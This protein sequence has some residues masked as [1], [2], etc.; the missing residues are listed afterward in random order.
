MPTTAFPTM[1]TD[2]EPTRAT[3]HA[4]AHAF[5]AI[6]RIHAI[7]HPKWWHISLNVQPNGLVT[8]A[9]ALP[10]GGAAQLR[11]D[12]NAHHIVLE[13]SSGEVREFPM[14]ECVTG[15]EMG[16]GLIAAVAEF[17][18][19]GDYERARFENDEPREYDPAA[20]RRFF[21]A[22]TDVHHALSL[23]RSN[24]EGDV[25]PLQVWPHGFDLAFEWFGTRTE[26]YEEH[27]EV[28]EHPSQINFGFYPGGD[29]YLYANPW[30][31][32][33]DVLLATP[34]P[35]GAVWHT[36]GWQGTK[37]PYAEVAGRPDAMDRIVAYTKAVFDAAAPTL[38]V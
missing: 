36:E 27:G 13:T 20:A 2:F 5:G 3:L 1:P 17:G 18:L 38:L 4:Y 37:L 33:G 9:M 25:G 19:T 35:S 16:E 6:P 22:L 10:G 31:F 23:H 7:S 32:D 28:I 12:L 24:L 26:T 15:T 30:P 29:A 8:E 21:A 11:M 34:L 14:N